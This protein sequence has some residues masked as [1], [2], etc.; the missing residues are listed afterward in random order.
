MSPI[1]P[2]M[3]FG[4]GLGP[5]QQLYEGEDE[6]EQLPDTDFR[7]SRAPGGFG[8]RSLVSQTGA[9]QRGGRSRM[10]LIEERLAAMDETRQMERT[11]LAMSSELRASGSVFTHRSS[12]HDA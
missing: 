12:G 4:R 8:R 6:A 1:Q 2:Q 3:Q 10:D 7:A 11:R 5:A 9:Q